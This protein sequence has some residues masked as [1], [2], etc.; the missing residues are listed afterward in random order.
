MATEYYYLVAGLPDIIQGSPKKGLLY[1]EVLEEIHT[2]LDDDDRDLMAMIQLRYDCDN[3]ISTLNKSDEFDSRGYYTREELESEIS[4]PEKAPAF[5]KNFLEAR[6][7]GKDLFPGLGAKEQLLAGY[8]REGV[9][10][11]NGFIREWITFELDLGNVVAG[12]TARQLGLPVEKSIIPLNDC[13]DKVIKS[14]AAD[15]GLSSEYSWLE[16]VL[17]GFGTPKKLE[18]VIDDI[19]W[20][21]ADEISEGNYFTI[22]AVLAFTVKLNSVARWMALDPEMGQKRIESLLKS[23]RSVATMAEQKN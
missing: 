23:M 1:S 10:H 3:I 17:N 19:R 5:I 15:F 14:S 22:E 18:D 12:K 4:S 20:Q 11:S 6:K 8:F 13:A 21:K 2:E 16:D 9:K 7:E